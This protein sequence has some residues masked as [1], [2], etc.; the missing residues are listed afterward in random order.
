MKK[1]NNT[2][3]VLKPLLVQKDGELIEKEGLYVSTSG[4][5]FRLKKNGNLVKC[6][7]CAP[8]SKLKYWRF[9]YVC[10]GK[11]YYTY[12]HRVIMTSF[13]EEVIPENLEVDHIDNDKNNNSRAN[14]Q[15]LTR[16]ENVAKRNADKKKA[17]EEQQAA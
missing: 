1:T 2:T 13:T 4:E 11:N 9:S 15:L 10:E 7:G 6:K 3:F 8:N 12:I 17:K 14:L 5:I 16:K